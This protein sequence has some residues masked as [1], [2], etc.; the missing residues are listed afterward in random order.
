MPNGAGSYPSISFNAGA[1][2]TVN[3]SL[4]IVIDQFLMEGSN[5]HLSMTGRTIDMSGAGRIGP[6]TGLLT[7]F[8]A[9][10]WNGP[11]QLDNEADFDALGNSYIESFLQNGNL[12]VLGSPAGSTA[13]LTLGTSTVNHGTIDLI[14]ESGGYSAS[15]IMSPGAFLQNDGYLNFQP[16]TGGFRTFDG[17]LRNNAPVAINTNTTF[18]NGPIEHQSWDFIIAPT[19]TMTVSSGVTT[20]V[21]DGLFDI[22]GVYSQ[23][24][25]TFNF[26]GGTVQGVA[27]LINTTLNFGPTSTGLG[28][29]ELMGNSTLTG[30]PVV[31]QTVKVLGSPS[32]STATTSIPNDI[33]NQGTIMMLSESGG[34]GSVIDQ[35]SGTTF[36]NNGLFHSMPGTAGTRTVKGN[37]HNAATSLID[38]STTFNSGTVSNSGTWT[39]GPAGHVVMTQGQDFDMLDGTLTIDGTFT[40]VNGT[41]SFLDGVVVG[42][43][44]L[45]ITSLDFDTANFTDAATFR[46]EGN[47]H[48]L[49]DVP[50]NT[51]LQ[52]MGAPSGSTQALNVDLPATF[53][54]ITEMVSEGGGYSSQI[55][56]SPGNSISNTG[57]FRTMVGTAGTRTV[58]GPFTNLGTAELNTATTFN[59]GPVSNSGAWTIDAGGAMNMLSGQDFDMLAGTFTANGPFTHANGTN[60]FLGG[61]VVGTPILRNTDLD[62]DVNNFTAAA[63]LSLEGNN[64]LLTGLHAN[65][66]LNLIGAPS[67]STQTLNVQTSA[68]LA[69]TLNLTAEGGGYA[70]N[71]IADAGQVGTNTGSINFLQGSNGTRSWQGDW[72]NQGT[73]AMGTNVSFSGG[74]FTNQ[75]D[76]GIGAGWTFTMAGSSTFIQESGSLGAKGTFVH[77]GGTDRFIGG[78]LPSELTLRNSALE[79]DPVFTSSVK[80]KLEGNTVFT[81]EIKGGQEMHMV[82]A[83]S[84]ST[85]TFNANS[86]LTSAGLLKLDSSGGGYASNMVVNG[87]DFINNGTLQV[88]PGAGGSRTLNA[89]THNNGIV[90]VD[91]VTL[92]LQGASFTNQGSGTV[93]GSG[94]ISGAATTMSNKGIINPGLEIGTL[95]FTGT[96][97]L[98][99]TSQI[100]FEVGGLVADTEHDVLTASTAVNLAGEARLIA[101]NGFTPSFGDQITILTAGAV[102]GTFDTVRYQGNLGDLHRVELVYTP[103]SV[104]AQVV[105]KYR[106]LGAV[107]RPLELNE[108][109]PGIGGQMNTFQVDGASGNGT[110]ELAYGIAP[111]TT[112][113]GICPTIG[114][115]IDSAISLGTAPVSVHGTALVQAIIPGTLSGTTVL[116]QVV[117]LTA[118]EL[119]NVVTFLVQ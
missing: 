50:S 55:V 52:L 79:F 28:V 66:T 22:Q 96:L 88:L 93:T 3:L 54:G 95:G 21:S 44:T 77:T 58:S 51:T 6:G 101:V 113:I 49:T 39:I 17:H 9:S 74:T 29:F 48:L 94:T 53:A 107:E 65:T 46:L 20:T 2:Y 75:G 78:K 97:N 114:F 84:G 19:A 73:V 37:F 23:S 69:G 4:D 27:D 5:A 59:S 112:P 72:L 108:P 41:D 85:Q 14:S 13:I 87:G 43:P 25:G 106:D 33:D 15:L 100:K 26:N 110:V 111:G 67:G 10:N 45:R 31:N 1:P 30:N 71:L 86:G 89:I 102:N 92:S 104:I 38:I 47:N 62:F 64:D 60:S 61:T 118:C 18:K 7:T 109:V 8:I 40:H 11:G 117:D 103:T 76:L 34:Y 116:F 24:S 115:H 42:T 105:F 90:S 98:E 83:P 32:G 12:R 82:G 68:P 35:A 70:S 119:T 80:L 57:T 81:G 91:G 99:P 56:A 16:G 63:D 36:T